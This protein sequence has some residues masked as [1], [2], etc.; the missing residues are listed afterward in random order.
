[1]E[2]ASA[3]AAAALLA[4]VAALAVLARVRGRRGGARVVCFVHPDLGIGGAERLVVDAAVAA[5]RH[6]HAVRVY[7]A[8][9]ERARCFDETRDGT[10][11]VV[12]A[13]DF[14]PRTVGGRLQVACATARVLWCAAVLLWRERGCRVVV[15]DQVAAPVPLL[16][17]FGRR[18]IFYC[19]FPDKLLATRRAT[20]L[21]ALVRR[22]YRLPF[23]LIE[24]LSTGAAHAVLVNSAFTRE[25]YA[26]AFPLLRPLP[27]P[28]V[29]HPA[30]DVHANAPLE[31]PRFVPRG[32]VDV[33]RGVVTLVSLNRFE[34]KKNLELAIRALQVIPALHP[35]R[36]T[37]QWA[38]APQ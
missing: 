19:H 3:A 36:R 17:L 23:D 26:E 2:P 16:R 24:E 15:V 37:A 30:I 18:V 10:L 32:G 7:T 33:P 20:G 8:H 13:G 22:L 38:H 35:R 14:F 6:G 25:V 34:R 21:R 4:L 1:M 27:P 29:L 12:V 5:R 11:E 9:H 28:A 31:W